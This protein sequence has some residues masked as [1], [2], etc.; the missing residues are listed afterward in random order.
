MFEENSADEDTGKKCCVSL[1]NTAKLVVKLCSEAEAP[2]T[3]EKSGD[4]VSNEP[5][6]VT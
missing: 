6:T 5:F 4:L 3:M 2:A 1:G